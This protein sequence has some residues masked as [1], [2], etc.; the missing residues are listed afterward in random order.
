[1]VSFHYFSFGGTSSTYKRQGPKDHPWYK[2]LSPKYN[3][4]II[5]IRNNSKAGEQK[6]NKKFLTFPL[7]FSND[8]NTV[9][10]QL[11]LLPTIHLQPVSHHHGIHSHI[12][13][14]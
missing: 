13:Y 8:Y 10:A 2:S 6:D 1:M 7:S 3:I 9:M 14:F 11:Q 12:I 5:T 4:M